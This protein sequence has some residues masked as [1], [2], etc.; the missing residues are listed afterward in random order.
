MRRMLQRR[1]RALEELAPR[2]GGGPIAAILPEGMSLEEFKVTLQPWFTPRGEAR[3]PLIVME[4]N[5]PSAPI[6][7]EAPKAP[8]LYLVGD[9]DYGEDLVEP[10]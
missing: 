5:R 7:F 6:T 10:A 4:D 8:T 9:Y 1:L 3:Q 2:S